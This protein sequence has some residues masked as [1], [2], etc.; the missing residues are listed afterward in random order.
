[1]TDLSPTE[2]DRIE[3]LARADDVADFRDGLRR[4]RA[5]LWDETR[6]SSFRLRHGV[7]GQ[8]QP[9]RQMLR[10]KVPGGVLPVAAL[11]ALAGLARDFAQDI[12]H[13]TTRQDLQLYHLPL[14]R[15]AEALDRLAAAGLTS[16]EA[17]GNTVRNVNTCA[18]AGACPRQRVDAGA[19]AQRLAR[20]WLRRPLVQAMPRK[21]KIA[22]SGCGTDCGAAL[23]HDLGLIATAR[24]GV[25]GFRVV[26]GGGLGAQ[27]AAAIDLFD[28]VS[29]ADLPAVVEALLRVHVAHSDRTDRGR[30]R[31]K[32]TI[33]RIGADVFRAAVATEFAALRGLEQRPWPPL[34]WHQPAPAEGPLAPDGLIAATDGSVAAIVPVPFGRL[35]GDQL[36]GLHALA[37]ARGVR[38]IRLT[39]SQDLV[40][41]GLDAAGLA[42]LDDALAAIGLKGPGAVGREASLINCPGTSTC[43]IG[44][45]NAPGLAARLAANA[46][47]GAPVRLSVSGCHNS[48]ALH[49][50]ADIGLHGMTR[51]INSQPAPYYRL[52]FGGEVE[53]GRFAIDGPLVPAR[54]ADRAVTLLR[55]AL[56][57]GRAPGESVRAW[58]ERLGPDGIAAVLAPLTAEPPQPDWR[59]DWDAD[60]PFAGPPRAAGECAAPQAPIAHLAD[61]ARDG[62]DRFDRF[63][64]ARRWPE[65]LKAGEAATALALRALL[66]R[67]GLEIGEDA[68]GPE[69]VFARFRASP[70]ATGAL[71]ETFDAV[72]AERTSALVTGQAQPYRE[73]LAWLIDLLR[74]EEEQPR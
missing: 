63:L 21:I 11:P 15:V 68:D 67:R 30:A 25:N 73:S 66:A 44:I 41:L 71:L 12:A 35:S 61:L 14:D 64:A 33:R 27:P 54:Q 60:E 55:R 43:R 7:Y 13:I 32:A 51:L 53:N 70:A 26:A 37:L 10:L 23:I 45:A 5:G 9:G 62:L 49:H 19:V 24:D 16:R 22:V 56:A 46:E 2:L 50:I 47:D 36:D 72:Q 29:E 39:R 42:G 31:L 52:H 74:P 48:C 58:A 20:L 59:F 3:P 65:A 18:L 4:Y 6:W 1:M 57:T 34:T 17:G 38:E 28:F 40:L 8:R 69:A